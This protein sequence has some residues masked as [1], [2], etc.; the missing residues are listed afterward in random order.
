MNPFLYEHLSD[1][2]LRR[3][4]VA[5]VPKSLQAYATAIAHIAEFD[6]RRLYAPEG[7]PS[8]CAFLTGELEL[9]EQMAKKLIRV[10]RTALKFPEIFL[11]LAD[12]RLNASG[13]ILLAPWLTKENA[14]ELLAAAAR[15]S[16]DEIRELLADRAPKLDVPLSFEAVAGSGEVSVRT[17]EG[18]AGGV[19]P[20][21]APAAAGDAGNSSMV[22]VRT[23]RPGRRLKLSPLGGGR[24]DTSFTMEQAARE[25]I[26]YFEQL[27]GRKV[28]AQEMSEAL[29]EGFR[30]KSKA[31]EQRRFG[32]TDR[33]RRQGKAANGRHIPNA[34]KRQVW[35]RDEGRCSF[36][37]ESGRRCERRGDVQFDHVEP[38]ARGGKSTVENLRL[39]CRAHNQY[40]AERVFGAGFMHGKREQAKDGSGWK[41]EA[42]AARA[43]RPPAPGPA[44]A[45]PAARSSARRPA[46]A[47]ARR[48]APKAAFATERDADDLI[49]CL[50]HLGF[51]TDEAR[52][53][54]AY[55][56]SLGDVSLEA[57][58]RAALSFLAPRGGVRRFT[59]SAAAAS[60]E[61]PAT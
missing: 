56:D 2:A 21:A 26:R 6:S 4:L 41:S 7:Y 60:S 20:E 39:L 11:A 17:P 5:A 24:Y 38:V 22:S 58:V 31:L 28:T 25:A 9:S 52:R 44:S 12:G 57:R 35:Q 8:M 18:A 42:P 19:S 55:C 34:V 3:G 59:G 45:P 23:P 14:R 48:P 49:P 16:K 61:V 46:P 32:V 51:R 15:R 40:E 29:A 37:A 13:V 36:V 54:A 33:P 47:S 43:T 27:A 50:R 1:G 53:A 10:G 30:S